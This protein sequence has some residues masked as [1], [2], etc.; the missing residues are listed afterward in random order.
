MTAPIKASIAICHSRKHVRHGP[1]AILPLAL[2]LYPLTPVAAQQSPDPSIQFRLDPVPT[3]A[4]TPAPVIA[5]LPLPTPSSRPAPVTVPTGVERPA[6]APKAAPTPAA[7]TTAAP[8]PTAA[9]RPA[10]EQRTPEPQTREAESTDIPV[11]ADEPGNVDA[12]PEA[13]ATPAP[14]TVPLPAPEP[15]E[16]SPPETDRVDNALWLWILGLLIAAAGVALWRFRRR[17]PVHST[18]SLNVPSADTTPKTPPVERDPSPASLPA[19]AETTAPAS[20]TDKKPLPSGMVTTSSK[21]VAGAPAANNPAAKPPGTVR[22]FS[23]LTGSPPPPTPTPQSPPPNATPS[24]AS[25]GFVTTRMARPTPGG[26]AQIEMALEILGAEQSEDQFILAYRLWL[27]NTG[28]GPSSGGTLKLNILPGGQD[29]QAQVDRFFQG[30]SAGQTVELPSMAATS[31]TP[32]EG[33]MR[34]MLDPGIIFRMN[35]RQVIIP[36][37]AADLHYAWQDGEDRT[38][39]SFVI[40]RRGAAGQE[41]LGPI[42]VDRGPR[43]LTS[44][45]SKPV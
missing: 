22:A 11:A 15:A 38:Q 26:R 20:Q 4:P 44:I 41:R 32:V 34:V 39:A 7:R 36:L 9:A 42:P 19:T 29:T 30:L 6:P 37:V 14:A 35:D 33:E 27:T 43:H 3:P 23:G 8:R 2:I 24:L 18:T 13:V 12:A 31:R 17:Q 28:D 16:V 1:G 10:P 5:P 25:S 45:A 40:G 21:A